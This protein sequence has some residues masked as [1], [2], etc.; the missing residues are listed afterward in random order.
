MVHSRARDHRFAP[1]GF[2]GP[3]YASDAQLHAVVVPLGDD[4]VRVAGTAELTGYDLSI[5]PQRI[6]NLKVLLRR[7]FPAYAAQLNENDFTPW[8][9]L[10][11]MSA[12]GVP[13]L[14]ATRLSNLYLSTGHGHLGWT[15]AAGAGF[16]H[17]GLSTRAAAMNSRGRF[18][19]AYP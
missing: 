6:E 18:E 11:P 17:A 7:M 16:E 13:I 5:P 4:R 12:D 10:R 2:Y 3:K 15:L 9:G 19:L 8:A 1:S 14:G